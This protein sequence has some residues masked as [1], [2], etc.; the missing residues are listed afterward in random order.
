MEK[1]H[2]YAHVSMHTLFKIVRHLSFQD[3]LDGFM[4]KTCMSI[5]TACFVKM[6]V[7][8]WKLRDQRVPHCWR[9]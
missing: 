9:S 5:Y 7:H 1:E 6:R 2:V 3:M 8:V 4:R